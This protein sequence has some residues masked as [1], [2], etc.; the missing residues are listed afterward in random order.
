MSIPDANSELVLQ[1]G[2]EDERGR[3]GVPCGMW[4]FVAESLSLILKAPRRTISLH[5]YMRKSSW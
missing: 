1:S 3:L 5:L 2:W 4:P